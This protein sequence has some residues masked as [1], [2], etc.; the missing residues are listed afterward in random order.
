M[1]SAKAKFFAEQ[2]AAVSSVSYGYLR[3]GTGL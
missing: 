3:D 2:A 1:D